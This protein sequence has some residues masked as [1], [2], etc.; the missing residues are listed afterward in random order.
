MIV[1]ST[2]L[3]GL[4]ASRTICAGHLVEEFSLKIMLGK[5]IRRM[6]RPADGA[7]ATPPLVYGRDDDIASF[8]DDEASFGR[9]LLL[10]P[11]D[12]VLAC[13]DDVYAMP[14]DYFGLVQTKGSLARLF[15][16]ATCNDGQIEPGYKGRITLELMNHAHHGITIPH[17][18]NVAQLFIHRCSMNARTPYNG[19]YQDADGPTIARFD[20]ATS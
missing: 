4:V 10:E 19:R 9:D 1:V 5:T 2:N 15:V 17:G 18:A 11:G 13:S 7:G 3:A 20:T 12:R 16:A 14:T 8:F 6:R